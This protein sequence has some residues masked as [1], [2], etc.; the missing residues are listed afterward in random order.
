VAG[1]TGRVGSRAVRELI[2]LGFRVRAAVRNAQRASTLVQSVQQLKLDD[3]D[4][5][6]AISRE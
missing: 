5:A 3:N 2:K 1:A 6:A 4:D